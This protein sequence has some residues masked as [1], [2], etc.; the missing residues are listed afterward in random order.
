MSTNHDHSGHPVK[1]W[2]FWSE[3]RM[4]CRRG[5]QVWTMVPRRHKLALGGAAVLMA[6]TSLT[7]VVIPVALGHLV[8]DV[9]DGVRRGASGTDLFR[10]AA[11]ILGVIA[12]FVMMRELFNVLRR[13]LVENTCTRIDKYLSVKV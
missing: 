5:R 4:I 8:D 11:V 1:K 6:L 10:T 7:A 3:L 13:F 9:A 2:G 12:G